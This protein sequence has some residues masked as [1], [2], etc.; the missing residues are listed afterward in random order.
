MNEDQTETIELE[1]FKSTSSSKIIAVGAI[2]SAVYAIAVVLP[3]SQFIG[4][5]GSGSILSFAICIA[6]LFGLILGPRYGFVFGGIAGILATIVSTQFGGLYLAIPTIILGPAIS[7]L[8]TGL[9]L[10]PVTEFQAIKVPGP[11]VTAIYLLLVILLYLIPLYEAWWFILPYALAMLVAGGLQTFR[12]KFDST[13]SFARIPL[14]ILPLTLIGSLADFS[15]MT[16]GSV[17]LLGLDA[18]LFGTV[19]FPVMLLERTASV[20]VSA[21]IAGV[22]FTAFRNELFV[23]A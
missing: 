14:Q 4:P 10:R 2:L 7:G 21:I 8:L 6:P 11:A 17:Y 13:A 15:M 1:S 12:F 19:I 18:F 20:I 16:L 22:L 3:M 5:A 9:C 23:E